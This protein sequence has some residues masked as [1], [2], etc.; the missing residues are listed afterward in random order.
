MRAILIDS[1]TKTV[2]E[3]D[4]V[5]GLSGIRQAIG[6]DL[7][8]A[9][10]LRDDS[11]DVVYLDDEGLFA[12]DQAYF[13]L[14]GHLQPYAG[15]GLVLGTV[16]DGEDSPATASV[17]EVL[18]MVRWM[19][20]VAIARIADDGGFDCRITAGNGIAA[21]PIRPEELDDHTPDFRGL[22][23]ATAYLAREAKVMGLT[24]VAALLAEAARRIQ[25]D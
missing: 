20:R 8:V 19:D 3:T 2:A 17:K 5:P 23:D 12:S 1:F 4:V 9:T 16:N 7:V 10:P 21:V 6:S 13:G 22:R 14:V 25:T 11:D 15:K 18:A 24:E